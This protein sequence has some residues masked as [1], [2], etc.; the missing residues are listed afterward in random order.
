MTFRTPKN[1]GWGYPVDHQHFVQGGVDVDDFEEEYAFNHKRIS[2]KKTRPKKGCP[3]NDYNEHVYVW[4]PD[5]EDTPWRSD[6]KLFFDF[7]GFQKYE[8]EICAGCDKRMRMRLTVEYT[9]KFKSTG[10]FG[11]EENRDSKFV[12]YRREHWRSRNL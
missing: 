8:R 12:A 5:T 9:K 11:Y 3:G 10:R 4:V 1:G 2:K 7:Y 6:D